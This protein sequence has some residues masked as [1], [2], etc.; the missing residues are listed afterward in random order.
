MLGM[1][2]DVLG[3]PHQRVTDGWLCEC[4]RVCV[5]AGTQRVKPHMNASGSGPRAWCRRQ[6]GIG[7]GRV[8]GWGASCDLIGCPVKSTSRR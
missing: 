1:V 4:G 8:R 2:D 7:S 6:D 5:S 3:V